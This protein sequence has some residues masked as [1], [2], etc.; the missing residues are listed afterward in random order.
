MEEF[1][2]DRVH[3]AECPIQGHHE[4]SVSD[5]FEQRNLDLPAGP[6]FAETDHALEQ[7]VLYLLE[8]ESDDTLTTLNL[9]N[10]ALEPGEPHLV[11]KVISG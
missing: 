5:Q 6:I 7:L 3:R 1:R 9:L 2:F 8:L 11:V 4:T 10:G